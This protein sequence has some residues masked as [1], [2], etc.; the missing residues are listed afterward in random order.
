MVIELDGD[1]EEQARCVAEHAGELGLLDATR[2]EVDEGSDVSLREFVSVQLA[3][4]VFE[5]ASRY[6]DMPVRRLANDLNEDPYLKTY[7]DAVVGMFGRDVLPDLVPNAAAL[8]IAAV[9]H[10]AVVGA[11]A[12][13]R[14]VPSHRSR[15]GRWGHRSAPALRRV[16]RREVRRRTRGAGPT[17]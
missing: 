17:Q 8:G 5:E 4:Y 7:F 15:R 16:R 11:R 13:V 3:E 9:L 1:A 14:D 6:R 2:V 12:L 10:T